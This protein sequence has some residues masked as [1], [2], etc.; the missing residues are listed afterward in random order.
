[1]P[2][3]DPRVKRERILLKGDVPSPINPPKGC[4][5]HTRCPYAFDRCLLGRAGPARDGGG[6]CRR[7]P[8]ARPAGG[9]KPAAETS[10][11]RARERLTESGAKPTIRH[12]RL[13]DFPDFWSTR[14]STARCPMAT[15]VA[16]ILS[17][18]GARA[19]HA[20][21]SAWEGYA[22]TPLRDLAAIADRLDLG[23]VLYKD[24]GKRFGLKSFKA[25]GGAYA[26]DRIV[27]A[28][29]ADGPDRGLRHRR[30][31]W[32]LRR[33]GR[34]PRRG[35][36]RDLCPRDRQ[37]G[38]GGGDPLLRRDRRARRPHL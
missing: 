3:P 38:P 8:S 7:L 32:P 28:R 35:Q 37:R 20:A 21:I 1:M 14:I 17:L 2:V 6:P 23:Q 15:S 22:P 16:A 18:A 25:L 24:E 9:G 4:R 34:S 27:A 5:F 13:P 31:S 30:Q 11:S 10:R 19:A 36:G 12:A 26:V 29:G 33:L